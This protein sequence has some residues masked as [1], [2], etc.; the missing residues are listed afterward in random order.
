MSDAAMR[1]ENLAKKYV[2]SHQRERGHKTLCDVITE[3]FAGSWRSLASRFKYVGKVDI[4]NGSAPPVSDSQLS[5]ERRT[6]SFASVFAPREDFWALQDVCFEIHQGEVVGVIGRNGA[7]KSTLLKIL[8]RITEPTKG[9]IEING[10]VASLLEVGT[11]FHPELT[12]RENIYLNGAMLGMSRAEIRAKFDEIVAFGE[13]ERFLDT[14]VKRYSSGMYVRLAFAVAAH[15]DPE[16]LIVDEVLAVGDTQFQ[17]KCLGKMRDVSRQQGRTVL[18]VSHSM[19]SILQLTSRAIV[20]HNGRIIFKGATQQAVESY[21]EITR[22]ESTVHYDVENIVRPCTD[23]Q[24]ARIVSLR[25]D[26]AMPIFDSTEDFRFLVRVRAMESLPRIRF[27]V[28]IF[29]SE[30]TPVGTCFS[31]ERPGV[32]HEEE[33]EAELMLSEPRLAPGH[34]YCGV[35]VGKGDHRTGHVDFDVVLDTL[36]FEVRPDQGDGGTVASWKRG[37]GTQ[38]FPDLL[39]RVPSAFCADR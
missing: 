34:Y 28:T 12:G 6:R 35:A 1:V 27:S 32:R 16:I 20:L 25:F 14:P 15:L 21:A 22:P 4:G 38:V 39:V 5:S 23:A 33:F 19:A 29:T 18:F 24:V 10:R 2:I 8:S 13:I 36:F 7:G 9:R 26:R 17:K 31:A 3:R 11:G 30:G 37:W